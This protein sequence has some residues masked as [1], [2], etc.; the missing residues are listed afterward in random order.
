MIASAQTAMRA[1]RKMAFLSFHPTEHTIMRVDRKFLI[2]GAAL[3]GA[4]SVF[5]AGC[6]PAEQAA[7]PPVS[8]TVGTEIDLATA[9]VQKVEGVTKIDNELSIKQ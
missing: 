5:G 9:L 3:A 8:T 1:L 6:S 4:I 2:L 7:T